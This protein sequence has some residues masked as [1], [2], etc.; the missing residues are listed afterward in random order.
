MLRGQ[1][2]GSN[3]LSHITPAETLNLHNY[4]YNKITHLLPFFSLLWNKYN[5][6]PLQIHITYIPCVYT[7]NES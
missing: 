7:L 3:Q 5:V 4:Y 1:K 2:N 6:V